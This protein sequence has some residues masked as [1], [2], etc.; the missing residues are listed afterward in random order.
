MRAAEDAACAEEEE[1]L[2]C[3]VVDGVKECGGECDRREGAARAL[4]APQNHRQ[5]NPDEDDPNVLDAV[6]REQAFEVVVLERVEHAKHG[7]GRAHEEHRPSPGGRERPGDWGEKVEGEAQHPVDR[8]LEHDARHQRRD[9]ARGR[10]VRTRE[11]DVERDY[12]GLGGEAPER[13]EEQRRSCRAVK[14]TRRGAK[15]RKVE[16][17]GPLGQG[18]EC[19]EEQ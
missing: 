15:G 9:V 5:P 11:P 19:D 3:C 10:G 14:V 8:D 18:K 2:E 6:E 4:L 7:R 17:P 13:Q 1:A 12:A 16:C